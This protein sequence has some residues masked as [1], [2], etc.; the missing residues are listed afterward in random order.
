MRVLASW[1]ASLTVVRLT[2]VLPVSGASPIANGSFEE[3]A[4]NDLPGWER[5]PWGQDAQL[6]ESVKHSGRRSIRFSA[7]GG[8]RTKLVVKL[9]KT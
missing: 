2:P 3:G 1:L 7:H 5:I 6:D 9:F 8:M 4:G